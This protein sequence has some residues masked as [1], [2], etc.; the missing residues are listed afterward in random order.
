MLDPKL[1]LSLTEK[2]V[3]GADA[4]RHPI[5]GFVIEQGKGAL[6]V[7]AQLENYIRLVAHTEGKDAAESLRVKC[8]AAN[9]PLR[10]V[11]IKP[12]QA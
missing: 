2:A 7:K 8:E 6:P 5:A 9:R 12:A 3:F 10:I 1:P 11:E 4:L